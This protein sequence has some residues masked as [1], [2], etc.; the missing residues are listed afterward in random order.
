MNR[1]DL[2]LKFELYVRRLKNSGLDTLLEQGMDA[3]KAVGEAV[4]KPGAL[5][6]TRAAMGVARALTGNDLYWNDVLRVTEWKRM[7]HYSVENQLQ[8]VLEPLVTSRVRV[9]AEGDAVLSII[10]HDGVRIG[11]TR[12]GDEGGRTPLLA[13]VSCYDSSVRYAREQLWK[14]VDPRR[15]V[16]ADVGSVGRNRANKSQPQDHAS[17]AQGLRVATDDL[18]APET[19]QFATDYAVYLRKCV[20]LDV[21]RTVLFY[22]IAG[23]GKS[24]IS[25]TLCDL[26]SMKSLRVRVEDLGELGSDPIL[27]MI[28]V[29]EPDVIILDDLDRVTSQVALLETLEVL[30]RKVRF[31]FATVNDV[32][33]LDSALVRPGR[34]DE[35]IEITTLDETAVRK[36]LG[37][38]DDAFEH[39]KAWPAAFVHEYVVRRRLLGKDGA[40]AALADLR[41]RIA[42]LSSGG[43]LDDDG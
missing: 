2:K 25:R 40:Q 3:A 5:S 18:I 26:L 7:F 14:T 37:E 6:V 9:N 32:E 39:V 8:E 31:V 38:F 28:K 17:P 27:E 10:S 41:K 12:D 36:M 29:F 15:I 4:E 20:E 30:H 43:N 42:S 19:S 33:R 35:L 1:D 16:L 34:F 13:H 11:W 22:G 21:R 23:C 24:T